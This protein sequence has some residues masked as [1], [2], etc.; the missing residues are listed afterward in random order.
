VQCNRVYC[1]HTNCYRCTR[2]CTCRRALRG[3]FFGFACL[4]QQTNESELAPDGRWWRTCIPATDGSLHAYV[5]LYTTPRP[6]RPATLGAGAVRSSSPA[7]STV[8]SLFRRP[9]CRTIYTYIPIMLYTR[10]LST[11]PF[12]RL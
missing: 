9:H 5:L 11:R 1:C 4:S 12:F 10:V 8:R 7:P 3:V 6:P 2:R